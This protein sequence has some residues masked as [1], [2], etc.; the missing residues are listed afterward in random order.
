MYMFL[1][2]DADFNVISYTMRVYDQD[3]NLAQK[4]LK[5]NIGDQVKT[6]YI[7]DDDDDVS[8]DWDMVTFENDY[9]VVT[10]EP[11]FEYA[12]YI[13]GRDLGCPNCEGKID[14]PQTD[15]FFRVVGRKRYR[16]A[17]IYPACGTRQA[18]RQCMQLIS[19]SDNQSSDTG[20]CCRM[21]ENSHISVAEEFLLQRC[22]Q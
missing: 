3:E 17:D 15:L 4:G 11:T 13:P 18:G 22:E 9:T 5:L 1:K 7:E 8:P 21:D 14:I 16:Q 10:Q 12:G 6:T 19:E 2:V 20:G